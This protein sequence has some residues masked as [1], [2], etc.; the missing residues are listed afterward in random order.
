MEI[1]SIVI[2]IHIKLYICILQ[3]LENFV[4]CQREKYFYMPFLY[5]G[6][7]PD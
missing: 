6:I 5:P 3:T 2:Y 4:F 1:H 7:Q